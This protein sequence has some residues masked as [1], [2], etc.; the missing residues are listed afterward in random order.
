MVPPHSD[1]KEYYCWADWNEQIIK[2]L[3]QNI[4]PAIYHKLDLTISKSSAHDFWNRYTNIFDAIQGSGHYDSTSIIQRLWGYSLQCR[5]STLSG[6]NIATVTISAS[7]SRPKGHGQEELARYHARAA[8]HSST[9]LAIANATIEKVIINSVNVTMLASLDSNFTMAYGSEIS[10][11]ASSA[12]F[13]PTD[14]D[15]PS[16]TINWSHLKT[17]TTAV[18]FLSD[19]ITFHLDSASTYH[20]STSPLDFYSFTSITPRLIHSINGSYIYATGLSSVHLHLFSECLSLI[21][22][23]V[24]YISSASLQLIS[25]GALCDDGFSVTFSQDSC[26][27]HSMA[28]PSFCLGHDTRLPSCLYIVIGS[29]STPPKEAHLAQTCPTLNTWHCC[30]SHPN[31][32]ACLLLLR[33]HLASGIIVDLTTSPSPCTHYIIGKQTSLP[34]L[35]MHSGPH[36][37][38]P[39]DIIYADIMSPVLLVMLEGCSY[40]LDIRNDFSSSGFAYT[41]KIKSDAFLIFL[42]MTS[43]PYTSAH[44]GAVE[45][46]HCTLFNYAH[47]M[48]DAA[49]LLPF[50]WVSP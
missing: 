20:I 44:I 16:C 14:L 48:H 40:T 34:I 11:C 18:I 37:T 4:S 35:H 12:L 8:G 45:H 47:A 30:L 36:V 6:P 3:L 23:H 7:R 17:T 10:F 28:T 25:I 21:L 19:S 13:A 5:Q 24:F 43:V 15:S 49:N 22:H 27:I 39:L 1:A 33:N 29:T 32:D 41:L 38:H 9:P 42:S 31:H 2:I 46:F 50:L 26:S